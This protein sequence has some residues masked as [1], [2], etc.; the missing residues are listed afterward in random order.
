MTTVSF[1]RKARKQCKANKTLRNTSGLRGGVCRGCGCAVQ[2]I[3]CQKHGKIV[4]NVSGQSRRR[5]GEVSAWGSKNCNRLPAGK[6]SPVHL[7]R[8]LDSHQVR[9]LPCHLP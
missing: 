3:Y 5:E 9:H 2:A 8:Y 4:I 7:A 6:G 1:I